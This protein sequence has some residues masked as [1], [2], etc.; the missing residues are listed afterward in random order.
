V[1]KTLLDEKSIVLSNVGARV[2]K[3]NPR[4]TEVKNFLNFLE[5]IVQVGKETT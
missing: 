3:E 1:N 4:G 2:K 5:K